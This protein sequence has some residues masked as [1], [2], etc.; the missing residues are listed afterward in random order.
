MR[1]KR[2]K[3]VAKVKDPVIKRERDGNKREK[4]LRIDTESNVK[5]E[6]S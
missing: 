3:Y 2:K 5:R 1:Q 6:A 4:I